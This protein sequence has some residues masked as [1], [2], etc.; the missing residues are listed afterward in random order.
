ME[1]G[2][3]EVGGLEHLPDVEPKAGED[4]IDICHCRDT[5]RVRSVPREET[6]TTLP[7]EL[8]RIVPVNHLE[9]GERSGRA[10]DESG[11]EVGEGG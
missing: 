6:R 2:E 7:L 8:C 4:D 11:R 5:V 9:C 3:L 1:D 10:R